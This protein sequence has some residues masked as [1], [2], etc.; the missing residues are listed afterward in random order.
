[1]NGPSEA[2][3]DLV[4]GVQ[5]GSETAGWVQDCNFILTINWLKYRWRHLTAFFSDL[6]FSSSFVRILPDL[7]LAEPG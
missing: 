3:S 2:P 7:S 5:A 6:A 1:M 4:A